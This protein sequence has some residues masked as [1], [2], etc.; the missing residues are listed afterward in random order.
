MDIDVGPIGPGDDAVLLLDLLNSTPVVDDAPADQWPD[1]A[2]LRRWLGARG[3]PVGAASLTAARAVREDLQQSVWG[4]RAPQ[5]VAGWLDG[6]H[7]VP[8]VGDHGGLVWHTRCP[9][10][11]Q[12]AVRAVLAYFALAELRPGRLR[13]CGNP[14]CRLF[15]L[16][17]S[18]SNT[19]RWCSMATCGN[20]LKARRHHARSRGAAG[21]ADRLQP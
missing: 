21:S 2:A 16:D 3:L 20:R 6:V 1:A 13:P 9:D 12:L 14:E 17:T 10:G 8:R 15:L 11:G 18:R 19:A 4:G 7:R 5:A